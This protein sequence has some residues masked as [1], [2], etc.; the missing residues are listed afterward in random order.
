MSDIV[1]LRDVTS[2]SSAPMGVILDEGS[3]DKPDALLNGQGVLLTI[4]H[5]KDHA[6]ATAVVPN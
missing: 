1:I 5:E 4:S 3:V 6:I 2:G